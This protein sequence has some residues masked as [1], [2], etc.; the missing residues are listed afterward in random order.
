V[1]YYDANDE[2]VYLDLER[3]AINPSTST[4]ELFFNLTKPQLNALNMKTS[5]YDDDPDYTASTTSFFV[6]F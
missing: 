4:L 5:D 1:G 3:Y 2:K 6:Q